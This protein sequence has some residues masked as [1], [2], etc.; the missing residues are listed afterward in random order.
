MLF[1]RSRRP[2]LLPCCALAALALLRPAALNAQTLAAATPDQASAAPHAPQTSDADALERTAARTRFVIGLDHSAQFQ[3]FSLSK[4]NRVI[5]E[6]AA[7]NLQLPPDPAS[8]SPV[9]LVK[10]FRAGLAGPDRSRVV[11]DVTSPV[12]VESAKIEKSKD[13]KSAR[14]VLEIA[15]VAG[16]IKP[17]TPLKQAPYGL[18]AAGLQPPLPQPATRPE[19]RAAKAFKPIIVIDPGHGGHDSGAQKNGTIEKEVVLAFGKALRDKLEATGRYKVLMTRETDVFVPLDERRAYAER[20]G[21]HLFIAVH[22]DYADGNSS[23]RG[24][25]VYSLR[26]SVANSLKR[27]AKDEAASNVLS[28]GE[29]ATV[30]EA[31]GDLEAVKGILSD[32]AGREVEVTRERTN[33]FARSIVEFMGASTILRDNP[34]QE[35]AFR[36]LKTAQFPSVLIELAYVTNK[37]DARLLKSDNWREKVADSIATAVHNYF[38]NK[39][40]RLPL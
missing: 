12:I 20:H 27:S 30:K 26:E 37:E 19:V 32:L 9:G 11:I 4:P 29:V 39:L 13:G 35:A 25:T 10:S 3:V 22:A 24:A 18:G 16:A 6:L 8:G 31:A 36:V 1:S 23:A 38:G 17:R 34:E 2:W 21:A 33:V 14:L 28:G 40:A 5:V 15:P 7:K